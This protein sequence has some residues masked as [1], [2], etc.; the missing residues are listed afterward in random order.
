MIKLERFSSTDEGTFGK[1]T[2]DDFCCYTVERP[3]LDNKP[4]E[5]CIPEGEYIL[6]HYTS[7]KFGKVF[8]VLGDTVSLYPKIGAKRSGILIHIANTMHDLAGCIGVGDSIGEIKDQKAVLNSAI[9]F[10]EFMT[11]IN[12]YDNIPFFISYQKGDI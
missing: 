1:L 6:S 11:K 4:F 7:P 10:K 5:S 12:A 8:A 3:W 9:T 2:F